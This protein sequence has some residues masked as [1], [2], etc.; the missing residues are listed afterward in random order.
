[1]PPSGIEK[2][3]HFAMLRSEDYI[4]VAKAMAKL[5]V[6][7]IRLTGGEPLVRK[8]L[9][10]LIYNLNQ[11][12]G[13]K[14][15]SITTNGILLPTMIDD[16]IDAGLKRINISLD[17]LNANVYQKLTR[18]GDLNQVLK[19][20]DLCKER[21]LFPL[22]LNVVLINGVNDQEL[23]DFIALAESGIEVRFIELMP[24]GEAAMWSKDKFVNLGELFAKREDLVPVNHIGDGGPCRYYQKVGNKG[25]IGVINPISD[26]FC[27]SC[28][29][30]RLTSDGMLRTCLH[31]NIETDLKPFLIDETQLLQ[32]ICEA[33]EKKP[34]KHLLLAERPSLSTRNMNTIGG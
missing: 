2:Q 23:D 34:E 31:S 4:K 13:I 6:E 8:G 25:I 32:A 1:M 5:G 26:H 10:N 20:I 15:V 28:N 7:K 21:G 18:G 14:E 17:S 11:I 30:L 27:K 19:G 12:E 16:L 33:V 29:R 22:K 3:S 24:I 9:P